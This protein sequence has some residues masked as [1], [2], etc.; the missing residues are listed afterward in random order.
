M[1]QEESCCDAP[2]SDQ[3]KSYTAG[4]GF[5]VFCYTL[6]DSEAKGTCR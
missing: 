6:F 1:H 3:L 4:A 5:D 2:W